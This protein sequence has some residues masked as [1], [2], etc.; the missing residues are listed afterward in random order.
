MASLIDRV[1]AHY[2]ARKS[3]TLEVPEWGEG[4]KPLVVHYRAPTLA[5]LSK[6]RKDSGG[7]EL[8]MASL[9]VVLCSKDEAG[10]S[11]FTPMNWR[12][13]FDHADPAVVQRISTAIMAEVRFDE[14]AVEAAEKN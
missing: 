2:D 11:L 8:K 14:A 6:V 4:N 10:K 3:F 5:V 9:L 7:D 12:D 1:T 13:I